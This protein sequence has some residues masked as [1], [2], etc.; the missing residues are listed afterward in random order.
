MKKLILLLLM[1]LVLSQPLFAKSDYFC[2][3]PNDPEFSARTTYMSYAGILRFGVWESS[4]SWADRK[5]VVRFLDVEKKINP[6]CQELK[7]G[8]N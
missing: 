5:D 3:F 6:Y 1:L 2:L 7:R 8:A 4:G